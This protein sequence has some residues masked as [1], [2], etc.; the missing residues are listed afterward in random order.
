[1][2]RVRRRPWGRPL[3]HQVLVFDIDLLKVGEPE[4]GMAGAGR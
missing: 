1:M 2:R 4:A 3:A